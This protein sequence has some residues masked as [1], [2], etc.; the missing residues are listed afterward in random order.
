MYK[1]TQTTINIAIN[2]IKLLPIVV[3]MLACLVILLPVSVSASQLVNHDNTPKEP[4]KTDS[5]GRDTP[6]STVQGLVSALADENYTLAKEYLDKDS[7]P[8]STKEK[9]AF[10]Q[11]F[12]AVLDAGGKFLP[13][14]QISDEA[15][16]DLDDKLPS[17]SEKVG[18]IVIDDTDIDIILTQ[19]YSKNDIIYWQFDEKTLNNLP[20]IELDNNNFVS[21]FHIQ[22]LDDVK[23]FNHKMT[24]IIALLVLITISIGIV[25]TLMWAV[26]WTVAFL[27]P[28]LS[29][30][31]FRITPKVILPLTIILVAIFLSDIMLKAGLPVTLRNPVGRVNEAVAW[32]ASS[33]LVLRLIDAVFNRAETLSIR[34]KRPEQLAFLSLFR[35]LAKVFMLILAVIIIFGNLGFDLTTGIAALGI[36]GLALAFGAQKTIENLIGSVV[37]VADRPI[38]VGDYCK[39]GAYEGVVIDIGIRSTRVRT[40]NRTVVTIPNGEFSALQIENYATRDMFHFLHN[41]YI[42]K[43]TNLGK[44]QMM[45]DTLKVFLDNHDNTTDEWTQVRISELRQDCYVVEVRTYINTR[46]VIEF[47]DLQTKLALQ[48]LQFVEDCGI[49]QALPTQKIQLNHSSDTNV[50][51]KD[52]DN[53]DKDDNNI[54]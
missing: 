14:L 53:K 5:F 10:I 54:V 47:Y 11:Q 4:V 8:K 26:F 43:D 31:Q 9:I 13:D 44:L 18:Q 3:C 21:R 39:F 51:I 6:R 29:G 52:T 33:W 35:K 27:Y 22:L 41:L 2:K 48:V 15:N 16:G 23:V 20:K 28:K 30:R 12:K 17:D 25:Y 1:N 24:H 42:S 7:L 49:K 36:G 50:N 46:D 38:H 40:L 19:H 32:I 37:V 45:I 34:K